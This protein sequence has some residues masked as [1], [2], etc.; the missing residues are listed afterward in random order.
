MYGVSRSTTIVAAYLMKSE[1]LSRDAALQ[2]IVAIKPSVKL[3][4]YLTALLETLYG[5]VTRPNYG[6]MEQL[7]IWEDMRW[8]IDSQHKS[9]KSYRLGKVAKVMK[10]KLISQV[11]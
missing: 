9:F 1:K 3:V 11:K 4:C 2:S 5:C 6:F 10:G 8:C 7:E